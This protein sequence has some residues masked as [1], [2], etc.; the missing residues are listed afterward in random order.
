[1]FTV[2]NG[3]I[4]CSS[5][6]PLQCMNQYSLPAVLVDE[7]TANCRLKLFNDK[8]YLLVQ[9]ILPLE[10]NRFQSE[11]LSSINMNNDRMEKYRSSLLWHFKRVNTF[12]DL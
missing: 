4:T 3:L 8:P 12:I 10:R 11:N 6:F 2:P 5:S 1:M 7:V 9:R